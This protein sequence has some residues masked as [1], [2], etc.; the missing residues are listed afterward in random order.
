MLFV[1]GNSTVV[2]LTF[3]FKKLQYA[4]MP[5]IVKLINGY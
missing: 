5:H 4:K 3:S 1:C 2:K